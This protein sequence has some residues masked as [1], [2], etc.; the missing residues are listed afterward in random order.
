MDFIERLFGLS[1]DNGDGTTEVL[2]L[3]V[4]AILLGAALYW[5]RHRVGPVRSLQGRLG[6][7][8]G[9]REQARF[10][11]SARTRV[12]DHDAVIVTSPIDMPDPLGLVGAIVLID[13][14]PHAV[15]DV[16]PN[17]GAIRTGQSLMMRVRRL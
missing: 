10:T 13:G 5:R 3:V 12:G 15:H 1:P 4:L 16:A 9:K 17:K 11:A 14:A 2:W 7:E 8:P 6:I